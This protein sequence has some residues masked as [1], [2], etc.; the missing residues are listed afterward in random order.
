MTH[1]HIQMLMRTHYH[2]FHVL[3]VRQYSEFFFFFER[4]TFIA[5]H[6]AKCFDKKVISSSTIRFVC[7]YSHRFQH[8]VLDQTGIL[9]L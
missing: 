4:M 5:T 8:T 7:I 9:C 2:L 6:F 3:G 1:I